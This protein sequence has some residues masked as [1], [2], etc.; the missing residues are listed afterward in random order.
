MLT[1]S[2]ALLLATPAGAACYADYK[3]KQDSPLRLHYGVAKI[4]EKACSKDQAADVLRKRLSKN[5]WSLLNVISV[6]DDSGLE[7]KR[8]NAGDFY[9]R[10]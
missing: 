2:L 1:L 7:A 4:P 8:E 10:Y 6:F 9:L 5:G 3:A